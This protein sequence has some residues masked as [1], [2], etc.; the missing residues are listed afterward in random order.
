MGRSILGEARCIKNLCKIKFVLIKGGGPEV[1]ISY[2]GTVRTFLSIELLVSKY[3]ESHISQEI[4]SF[5][6]SSSYPGGLQ[7]NRN[8]K[9]DQSIVNWFTVGL[10]PTLGRPKSRKRPRRTLS[11]QLA[12]PPVTTTVKTHVPAQHAFCPDLNVSVQISNSSSHS[13]QDS[14][15]ILWRHMKTKLHR[16]KCKMSPNQWTVS[17]HVDVRLR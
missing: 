2:V 3:V 10:S 7:H 13:I 15:S 8:P 17:M 14:L 6:R 16:K 4:I 12:S 11:P 1:A 9:I 5:G